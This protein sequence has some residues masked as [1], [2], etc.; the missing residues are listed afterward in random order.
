[1]ATYLDVLCL[2]NSRK[3]GGKCVA[4]IDLATKKWIRPVNAGGGALSGSDIRF[5]D[6][7]IPKPLDIVKIPILRPE[8]LYYQPENWVINH[9]Y[10]W[11]K[12]G[13]ADISNLKEYLDDDRYILF[14]EYDALDADVISRKPINKSLVLIRVNP[15]IFRKTFNTSGR[16]Q[17]RAIFNYKDN[18]YN[19]VVTDTEWESIFLKRDGQYWDMGDY[20]F[21]RDF[22]F[23]IG[24]GEVF[25]RY[26]YKLVVTVIP[27]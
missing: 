10:Y 27:I 20:P 1:M 4:G 16:P 24:L 23:I 8:P 13:N 11:S 19:L 21:E 3:L 25:R 18:N 22:Y 15:V 7:L 9:E 2:A 6:S 17:I 5:S 12:I 14:N 26:H